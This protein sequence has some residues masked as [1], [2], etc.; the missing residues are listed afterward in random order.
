MLKSAHKFGGRAFAAVVWIVGLATIVMMA[1]LLLWAQSPV[2]Y[3]NW[4]ALAEIVGS[5]MVAMGIIGV[6]SMAPNS[7]ERLPGIREFR[8]QYR[9]HGK[10][11]RT[12]DRDDISEEE[13]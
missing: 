6:A 2:E 1:V 9:G 4:L 7:A 13:K 3:R 10:D 12:D 5:Y 11:R 8:G